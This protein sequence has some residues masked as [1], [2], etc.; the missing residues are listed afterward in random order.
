MVFGAPATAA[1]VN[2]MLTNLVKRPYKTTDF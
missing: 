2:L 1:R